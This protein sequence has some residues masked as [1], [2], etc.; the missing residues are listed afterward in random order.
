MRSRHTQ[1]WRGP[2]IVALQG[3]MKNKIS[4]DTPYHHP[5]P[6]NLERVVFLKYWAKRVEVFALVFNCCVCTVGGCP[7][8]W[9]LGNLPGARAAG[10]TMSP[11][12]S[13]AAAPS[14]QSRNSGSSSSR[15]SSS[16]CCV[17]CFDGVPCS[18]VWMC[19]AQVTPLP[20]ALTKLTGTNCLE[21]GDGSAGQMSLLHWRH[22]YF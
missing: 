6:Q 12:T 22:A 11:P 2:A 7:C 14:V 20:A 21:V 19:L 15:S 5:N 17:G 8:L 1:E 16:S 4:D 13:I 3:A 10:L 9:C 18:L